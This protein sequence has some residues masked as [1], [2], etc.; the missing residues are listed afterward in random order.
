LS[1]RS[2]NNL[3]IELP[4][5]KIVGILIGN[6]LDQETSDIESTEETESDIEPRPPFMKP[7]DYLFEWVDGISEF[8]ND[9][10]QQML[11]AP[12]TG[13]PDLF[14]LADYEK[15]IHQSDAYRWLLS[16]ICQH[17]RLSIGT[18]NTMAE[19]GTR[20]LGQLQAQASLHMMSR[21]K[22]MSL[23]NMTFHL[24]WNLKAY[25]SGLEFQSSSSNVLEKILCLTGTWYEAQ[26]MTVSEYIR[27]TWPVTGEPIESILQEL[28]KIP[29]G[30]ECT[31]K[32]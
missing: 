25:I 24:E 15:F 2:S 12:G 26:A 6:E 32:C 7:H 17:G 16:K 31:C 20:I 5:S 19:I 28:L 1:L 23:A 14:Q 29:E 9:G 21:R 22:P 13:E 10:A 4:N 8:D 11:E 18:P 30:Q 3:L 27:Q